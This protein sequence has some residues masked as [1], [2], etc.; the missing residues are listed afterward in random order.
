[1]LAM[2]KT[3]VI[4]WWL[5][6]EVGPSGKRQFTGSAFVGHLVFGL[7]PTPSCFPVPIRHIACFI[8]LLPH[9]LTLLSLK[10]MELADLCNHQLNYIFPPSS[11]FPWAFIIVRKS[12]TSTAAAAIPLCVTKGCFLQIKTVWLCLLGLKHVAS[13][14]L[15]C[16]ISNLCQALETSSRNIN[17]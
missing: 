13:A 12:L 1:M 11:H 15:Y 10:A 16:F 4:I 8:T 14:A 17:V 6:W 5:Y 7:P 3:R 2:E 9:V